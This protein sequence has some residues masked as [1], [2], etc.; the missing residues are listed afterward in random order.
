MTLMP[1]GTVCTAKA[2]VFVIYRITQRKQAVWES[3]VLIMKKMI[4]TAC[5]TV[6]LFL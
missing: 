4:K 1:T 5:M 3:L 6:F 2:K